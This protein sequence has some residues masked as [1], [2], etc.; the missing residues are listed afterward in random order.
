MYT[1]N[2]CAVQPGTS[3]SIAHSSVDPARA[4]A[5]LE[6]RASGTCVRSPSDM[7]R[8][9]PSQISPPDIPVMTASA[10]ARTSSRLIGPPAGSVRGPSGEAAARVTTSADYPDGADHFSVLAPETAGP[11]IA[12]WL[13]LS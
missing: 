7:V 9:S 12:W 4:V 1:W 10:W 5:S 2:A 11:V 6:Q 13:G 8:C 3:S